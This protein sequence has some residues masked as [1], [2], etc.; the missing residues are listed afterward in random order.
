MISIIRERLRRPDAERGFVL[1]GFPR[2]VVQAEALD[3]M[4]ERGPSLVVVDI[5]VPEERLVERLGA[6]RICRNCGWTAAPGLKACEKCGGELIQRRDDTA[7]VVRE[8]LQV[9]LRE[10]QPL[11]EFYSMRRTFRSVDGDQSP[12]AV[13]ADVAAAV[14][15]VVGVEQ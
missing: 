9:Y 15:S 11:V 12:D 7:D 13:A 2:T 14:A 5:E 8:R 1:D 10:T 6:R 3:R 4:A